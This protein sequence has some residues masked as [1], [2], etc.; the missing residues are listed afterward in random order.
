[1]KCEPAECS[2]GDLVALS[3]AGRDDAFA[4]IVQVAKQA[5]PAASA[6]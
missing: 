5:L 4:E 3:L 2:D 6:S 1:M